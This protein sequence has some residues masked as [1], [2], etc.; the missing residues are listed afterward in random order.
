VNDC[1]VT[2]NVVR[3]RAIID[4]SLAPFF[5]HHGTT[6]N[7]QTQG[8]R[9]RSKVITW[10]GL[11]LCA[12]LQAHAATVTVN[13][14]ADNGPGNCATTCTLRD[15]IAS[16]AAGDSIVFDPGLAY[17]ATITLAGQELLIY[18]S[19]SIT[20]PGP[21]QLT[22]DANQQ[23]RIVE[24]ALNATVNIS[25]VTLFHGA[26]RGSPGAPDTSTQPATNGGA[27]FGGA[28]LINSGAS[29]A[30]DECVVDSNTATGGIGGPVF[31]GIA[32]T[33]AGAG[34]DAAGGAIYNLGFFSSTRC[35]FTDN[36]TSGG[37]GGAYLPI[38]AS[39]TSGSGGNVSGGAI[40]GNGQAELLN[41]VLAANNATGGNAGPFFGPPVAGTVG[42]NGGNASAG[43]MALSGFSVLQFV[44]AVGNAVTGGLGATAATNG[45]AGSAT[46]TD[47]AASATVV[48]RSSV[49]ASGGGSCGVDGGTILTQGTNLNSDGS[50]AGFNLTADPQLHALSIGRNGYPIAFPAYGS[51]V[52]D[53]ANDCNDAFGL[54]VSEDLQGTPR[55]QGPKCDIGAIEADYIFVNGFEGP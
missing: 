54:V 42:G 37:A 29:L 5:R 51:P 55:P 19:L 34:G 8:K 21:G 17:P 50:C 13:S 15:A 43:A 4:R 38:F 6:I 2:G 40:A 10:I 31:G 48:A 23:S 44:T 24:I 49:L 1:K 47:L 16:A 33:T 9:M 20:G 35:A 18:K 12:V 41:G 46:A 39:G 53:A 14:T 30:L 52:I 3:V 22:I 11:G 26:V 45:S 25:G 7:P 27:A 36:T 32:S 28:I